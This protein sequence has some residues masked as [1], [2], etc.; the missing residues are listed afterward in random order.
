[1]VRSP[2]RNL[3]L[4]AGHCLGRNAAFVPKYDHTKSA[5]DQPYGIWPVDEWFRDSQYASDRSANSD[6]DF[7]FASLK[8]D[9]GRN[10][11]DVVGANTPHMPA[12]SICIWL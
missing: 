7:A 3:I 4:T 9:G 6:L 8:E 2:G 10:A 12:Q 5:G 1:M 11:Q